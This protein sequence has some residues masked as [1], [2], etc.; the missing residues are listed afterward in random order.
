VTGLWTGAQSSLKAELALWHRAGRKR[1]LPS[2]CGCR[3][4]L[5][6]SERAGS[7]GPPGAGS[8]GRPACRRRCGECRLESHRRGL[9]LGC[10]PAEGDRPR[11]QRSSFAL[12]R[13]VAPVA[14]FMADR[15]LM[16]TGALVR[17]Q[18]RS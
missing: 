9:A 8:H 13:A 16:A 12:R 14:K 3:G 1:F 18:P 6:L 15:S 4:A 10:C 2:Q 5:S 7:P 17:S 11:L